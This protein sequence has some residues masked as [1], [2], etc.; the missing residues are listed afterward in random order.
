MREQQLNA[1]GQGQGRQRFCSERLG[2]PGVSA[3]A[4]NNS[5]VT[6]RIILFKKRLQEFL[7]RQDDR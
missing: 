4:A 1:V 6:E 5:D 3:E 2:S 7:I